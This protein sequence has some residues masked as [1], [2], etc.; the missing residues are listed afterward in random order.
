[1]N[2]LK[3]ILSFNGLHWTQQA[4][5][6]FDTFAQL[7]NDAKGPER[8]MSQF[9]EECGVSPATFSRIA[10]KKNVKA[11]SVTLLQSIAEHAYADS[12]VCLEQLLEVNGWR[13]TKD[14]ERQ[15][16]KNNFFNQT[17]CLSPEYIHQV[18]M[19]LSDELLMRGA[20][21]KNLPQY[22]LGQIK[23]KTG[24]FFN[25]DISY[26]TDI[27]DGY[28][29]WL[30]K[31]INYQYS[32]NIADN[33]SNDSLANQIFNNILEKYSLLFLSDQW[34]P[35]LFNKK[36]T[37]LV[38]IDKSLYTLAKNNLMEIETRNY[39]SLMLIDLEHFAI[40]DEKSLVNKCNNKGCNLTDIPKTIISL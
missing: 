36:K 2:E 27:F 35:E 4:Q 34:E 17:S 10:N 29:T 15:S 18:R 21:I 19:I 39:F 25:Y 13:V 28:D 12:H 3:N 6:D 14:S 37:T 40:L 30:I 16:S 8:A 33:N 11:T 26:A 20:Y 31:I 23:T 1:M 5:P 38:F 22:Q 9:A 7:I 32:Q 24:T